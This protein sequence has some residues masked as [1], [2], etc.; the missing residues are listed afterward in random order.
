MQDRQL[1]TTA[2]R[3]HTVAGLS[4]PALVMTRQTVVRCLS[5]GVA[6]H[7]EPH[8][9]IDVSL[10]HRLLRDGAVT[11]RA[12]DLRADMRRVV[13]PDMRRVRVTKH[14]LPREIDA[15]RF[16]RRELLDSRPIGRD[17]GVAD[18]ARLD[19]RKPGDRSFGRALMAVV[20]AAQPLRDVNI[21]RELERLDRHRTPA[22]EIA[23]GRSR[24]GARRR[25]DVS[26]IGGGWRVD[27]LAR[28]QRR[29]RDR[30]PPTASR[31][32]AETPVSVSLAARAD[33]SEVI[34]D[35]PE[36]LIGHLALEALHIELRAGAVAEHEEDLAVSL[37]AFPRGIDETRRRGALRRHRPVACRVLAVTERAPF[38]KRLLPGR[39]RRRGRRDR[40]LQLLSFRTPPG[41]LSKADGAD[42]K[43]TH[44]NDNK[45]IRV[46]IV[47]RISREKL[48][49]LAES[50]A[51]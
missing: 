45:R 1:R 2:S 26:R 20:G 44:N 42:E 10:R 14:T 16:E 23:S 37:P 4:E 27:D 7:A 13:E 36:L 39:H 15:L 31:R 25:E 17:V 5:L 43:R 34:D 29:R 38:L 50:P 18:H 47:P 51:N 6:V 24:V 41:V 21:V 9:Q 32:E 8:G 40:V 22:E 28:K 49:E 33:A 11:R 46:R 3:C 35:V 30:R 48:F 19:A 12:V